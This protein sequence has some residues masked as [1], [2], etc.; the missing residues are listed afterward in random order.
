MNGKRFLLIE[1]RQEEP[2]GKDFQKFHSWLLC[3]SC[4]RSA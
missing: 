4:P 1:S 3:L 2:I